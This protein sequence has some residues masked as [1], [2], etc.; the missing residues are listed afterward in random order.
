MEQHWRGV[1]TLW[2]SYQQLD[3]KN[4]GSQ[5]NANMDN[6]YS[7][8][9]Y[10]LKTEGSLCPE[11]LHSIIDLADFSR[12]M[13]KSD[14]ILLP[15]IPEYINALNDSWIQLRYLML[16]LAGSGPP[17]LSNEAD[18]AIAESMKNSFSDLDEGKQILFFKNVVIYYLRIGDPT[19]A[20]KFNAICMSLMDKAV[21]AGNVPKASVY[22]GAATI[23]Q[24]D[25]QY[26]KAMSYARK[27]RI[28]ARKVGSVLVE[29][30]CLVL[31]ASAFASLG[32]LS[33]AFEL[34][35]AAQDL[36]VASGLQDSDRELAIW[37]ITAEVAFNKTQYNKAYGFYHLI[38]QH[39]SPAKSP[40]YYA[41][42][43][44][45]LI[46]IEIILG[47]AGCETGIKL[48]SLKAMSE[49]IQWNQG[50]LFANLLEADLDRSQEGLPR[51]LGSHAKCFESARK[52]N[53]VQVMFKCLEKLGD[54]VS[55]LS[56]F[57]DAFHWTGTYFAFS[58]R[59]KNL[60]HT[61]QSLQYLAEILLEW[62]DKETSLSLFHTVLD[63]SKETGV[64]QRQVDCE[65]RI[66]EIQNQQTRAHS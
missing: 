61:Y 1:L 28:E 43:A 60:W 29:L 9:S 36:V 22:S 34:C 3:S 33:H 19:K 44:L 32:D 48:A 55:R 4:L 15:L 57:D 35:E 58:R 21:D 8:I 18:I 46:Q 38:V 13:L 24:H 54:G 30:D 12:I 27:G 49:N 65:S 37:D 31:E 39:T 45:C 26:Q 17:L 40:H 2:C 47:Q 50:V 25:G 52:H 64:H 23:S 7:V 6:I 66:A 11:T 59:T 16:R 14:S 42:A 41:Y 10:R 62:G 20:A 51:V 53:D 56:D 5:L 63:G